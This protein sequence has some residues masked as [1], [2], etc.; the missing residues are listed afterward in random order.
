MFPVYG[1]STLR[2]KNGFGP[3]IYTTD[4]RLPKPLYVM[5][6][7]TMGLNLGVFGFLPT[8][9][10]KINAQQMRSLSSR[11]V[12]RFDQV[13]LHTRIVVHAG[14]IRTWQTTVILITRKTRRPQN[15]THAGIKM[16]L[17]SLVYICGYA[18]S[19]RFIHLSDLYNHLQI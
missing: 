3:Q 18:T 11:A 7:S 19:I 10:A 8:T 2:H 5:V 15:S 1:G 6:S 14:N 12:Q 17:G 13:C 4:T 9:H 16:A